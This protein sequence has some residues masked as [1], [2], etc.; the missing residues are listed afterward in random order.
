MSV[1][2]INVV[3]LLKLASQKKDSRGLSD[4][5]F[6]KLFTKDKPVLFAFHG[7][8]GL[9]RDLFF[10]RENRQLITHGYRE[11]GDVT[12][13][14]DM[15]VVNELDRF[16]LAKDAAHAVYGKQ[17]AEFENEMDR[18]LDKHHHYIREHGDD[19]PEVIEWKWEPLDK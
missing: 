4:E 2:F 6:N 8:E 15:R 9:I 1:R 10:D 13:P 18:L 19:M 11:N 5:A 3:D 12:T 14:F 7:Y 16:H 17:A